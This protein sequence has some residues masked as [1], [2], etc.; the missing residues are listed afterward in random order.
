MK[1]HGLEFLIF[2]RLFLSPESMVSMEPFKI[3]KGS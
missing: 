1:E 3:E 2:E